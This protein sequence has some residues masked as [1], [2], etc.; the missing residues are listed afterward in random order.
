MFDKQFLD[1]LQQADEQWEET[2]LQQTLARTPER[3][4]EFMTT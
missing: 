2:T 3:L 1:A 4:D